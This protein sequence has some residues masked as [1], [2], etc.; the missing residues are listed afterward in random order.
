MSVILLS[1]FKE[2]EVVYIF[3]KFLVLSNDIKNVFKGEAVS[4]RAK[5]NKVLV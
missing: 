3:F 2:A 5:N 4:S 1:S